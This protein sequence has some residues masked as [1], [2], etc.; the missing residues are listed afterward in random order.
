MSCIRNAL[1]TLYSLG[2]FKA[3]YISQGLMRTG[4]KLCDLITLAT[5]SKINLARGS[6]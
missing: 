2:T 1:M 4:H 6:L 5:L 3:D